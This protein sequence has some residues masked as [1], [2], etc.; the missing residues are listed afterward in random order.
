MS[1]SLSRAARR[2]ARG[3][4]AAPDPLTRRRGDLC[5]PLDWMPEV[6]HPLGNGEAVIPDA[7]LYYQRGP[8]DGEHGPMLRAFLE[9]DRATMGPERLAAKL[10]AYERLH[11]YVPAVPGRR[12]LMPGGTTSGL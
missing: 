2:R 6:H 11:R 3:T 4:P 12:D 1:V 7:L 8:V 10:T 5:R 9:V